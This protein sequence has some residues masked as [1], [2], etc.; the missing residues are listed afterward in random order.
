VSKDGLKLER[1]HDV[2]LWEATDPQEG[3]TTIQAPLDPAA[4]QIDPLSYL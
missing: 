4:Y 3:P 2:N 1:P